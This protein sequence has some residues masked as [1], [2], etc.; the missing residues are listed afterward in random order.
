MAVETVLILAGGDASSADTASDLPL[1]DL[2]VA[3]DTGY[4]TALALGLPV[5]ILIGDMD[6]IQA[7]KVPS[8]VIVERH[9]V[10]KDATDL[11]LALE[12][13]ARDAPARVVV[14]GGSGGRLDHELAVAALLC[15]PRW[16]AIEEI[17]WRSDR[18]WAHVVRG[19]RVLHGD[20]G[21]TVSLLPVGGD[22]HGITTAGL[23]WNLRD[24]TLQMGTTRGVSNVMT[25]PVTDIRVTDGALLVVFPDPVG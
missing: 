8:H 20:V 1:A 13:V 23:K 6:S 16:I 3:A 17:D 12:L 25:A 7:T 5:D 2:V 10:D 15:S 11:E 4:D 18:G 22:A 24:E 19:R 21:A 14:L 9:P